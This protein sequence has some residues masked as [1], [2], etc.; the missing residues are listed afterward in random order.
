MESNMIMLSG[1]PTKV[2]YDVQTMMD[3]EQTL[4]LMTNG[5]V[6]RDFMSLS[7]PPYDLRVIGILVM[8]GING[9]NREEGIEKRLD[10]PTA[11]KLVS[12]HFKWIAANSKNSIEVA[13]KIEDLK[14]EISN[15]ILK[16]LNLFI[17]SPTAV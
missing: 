1:V 8:Q 11:Q 17:E 16:G 12:E 4:M 3:S 6:N 7:K 10:W 9:A 13:Q 5:M 15:A 14:T 2:F